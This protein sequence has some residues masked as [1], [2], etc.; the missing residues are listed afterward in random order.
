MNEYWNAGYDARRARR[1][2]THVPVDYKDWQR[3]EWEAGWRADDRWKRR[4]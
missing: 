3:Y 4:E 2:I 1:P